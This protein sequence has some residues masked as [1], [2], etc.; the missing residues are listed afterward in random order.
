MRLAFVICVLFVGVLTHPSAFADPAHPNVLF[1][2]TDDQRADTIGALGNTVI[3]TPHLD[4]LAQRGFTFRNAYCMGS[5]MPAVCNPSRHMVLSGMSLYRYDPRQVKGT[6]GDVMRS[7]GYA[8][9]HLSKRGN[10]ACECHKAFEF[11]S[12][13][14]DEKERTSGHH[15]RSAADRA[16]AYLR[17]TWERD[18]P[19]FMY[20]A[21]DGPHDPRVAAEEWL[22]LYDRSTIPLP[23]NF[24]P[25]HP[26]DNGKLLVR[27]EK[28]A[29]WPRTAEEVRRHLH[30]YYACISS[31][32]HQ[33]GRLMN[34]L[35]ELDQHD[36]TLI[37]FASDHGLAIGSHGL[38]DKQSLYEH[39][40]RSPLII[41]RAQFPA[42]KKRRLGLFV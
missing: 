35:E 10:E 16:I 20:L 1:L 28:L 36:T 31:L 27:D 24:L 11:S 32:D 42:G 38:L 14:E 30:E 23:D 15:G 29:P 5:T 40:M 19:F 39:S 3:H 13:L 26:F 41:A 18:K 37:V 4:K 21:F 33:I 22:A 9:F 12:Y 34:T 6:F 2:F 25:Y 17:E 8:T 7:A